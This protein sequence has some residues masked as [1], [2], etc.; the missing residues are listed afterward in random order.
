MS[1]RICSCRAMRRNPPVYQIQSLAFLLPLAR[2][3][4]LRVHWHRYP[5]GFLT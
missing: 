2:A 1:W 5:L 4:P 3:A